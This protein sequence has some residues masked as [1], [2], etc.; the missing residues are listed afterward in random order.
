MK[1]VPCVCRSA[2]ALVRGC[3]QVLPAPTPANSPSCRL[4][5]TTSSGTTTWCP[6]KCGRSAHG[7]SSSVR[8]LLFIAQDATSHA[9]CSPC[10]PIS[11]PF[12]RPHGSFSSIAFG[13]DD[14]RCGIT[15]T[16]LR[17]SHFELLGCLMWCVCA[18]IC[19]LCPHALPCCNALILTLAH[20]L[21]V[22]TQIKTSL[23][24]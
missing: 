3:R 4:P 14:A 5:S 24:N 13:I 1:H 6:R 23:Q 7:R 20:S 17:K 2:S 15:L 16:A 8:R 21:A 18:N 10:A 11:Q 9:G 19:L 22:W 12:F